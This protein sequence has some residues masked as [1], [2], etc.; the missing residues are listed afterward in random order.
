MNNNA[1]TFSTDYNY[2][3][4][5][6]SLIQTL[7]N[8][9]TIADIYCRCIDFTSSQLRDFSK[10][11]PDI[12]MIDDSPGLENRKTILKDDTA[13]T[14]YHYGIGRKNIRDLSSLLYSPRSVYACHSRFKTIPYL[15]D[16]DYS[17]V[18]TLDVDTIVNRNINCV[19]DMVDGYDC[20]T[21]LTN[22]EPGDTI[23]WE[24]SNQIVNES[25]TS[26]RCM[27]A[28]GFIVINNTP[29]SVKLWTKVRDDIFMKWESWN[30]DSDVINDLINNEFKSLTI[31]DTDSRFKDSECLDAT[32]MW[33]G[34]SI[35]KNNPKFKSIVSKY[36]Q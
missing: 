28:E 22:I 23:R 6:Q 7:R 21:I 12:N 32:Y 3:S 33:S 16:N 4:Y 14:F 8:N 20:M 30:R 13:S 18:L 31:L 35:T 25:D 10:T 34:E 19:F 29:R 24:G 11:Y 17:C 15:L 27:F 1:V 2:I 9:E 36:N 5:A 26:V